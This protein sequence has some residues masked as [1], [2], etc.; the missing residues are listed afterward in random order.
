LSSRY[1][2]RPVVAVGREDDVRGGWADVAA[3]IAADADVPVTLSVPPATASA[4]MSTPGAVRKT[5]FDWFD[6]LHS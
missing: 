2:Q 3:T 4:L 1:E 6:P 5:A